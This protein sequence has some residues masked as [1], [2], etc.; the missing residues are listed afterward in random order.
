MLLGRVVGPGEAAWTDADV[1]LALAYERWLLLDAA[2]VCGGCGTRDSDWRASDGALLER[3]E[4]EAAWTVGVV[5]CEGCRLIAEKQEDERAMGR[6]E[7]RGRHIVL[8]RNVDGSGV[9][10]IPADVDAV[11]DGR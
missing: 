7:Q 4:M 8:R 5:D 6:D 3:Y 11:T 2:E 10:C 1:A 9:G